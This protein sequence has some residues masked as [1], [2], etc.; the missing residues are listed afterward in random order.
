MLGGL[1]NFVGGG[2]DCNCVLCEGP[3]SNPCVPT[4]LVVLS[5]MG[6]WWVVVLWGSAIM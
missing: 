3:R 6:V 4:M 1:Y 5:R 2:G